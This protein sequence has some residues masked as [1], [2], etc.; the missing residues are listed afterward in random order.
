MSI[1]I[2]VRFGRRVR[3]LRTKLGMS[4]QM[5]AD[6]ACIHRA[7]LSWIENGKSEPCLRTISDL[8]KALRMTLAELLDGIS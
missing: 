5:L 7:T 1:D 3:V 8:A 2:A 4:Q 6:H